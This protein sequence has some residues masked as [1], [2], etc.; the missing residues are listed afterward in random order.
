MSVGERLVATIDD[1]ASGEFGGEGAHGKAGFE[2]GIEGGAAA[3]HAP[4][5][6]DQGGIEAEVAREV[7]EGGGK[8]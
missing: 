2:D 3:P 6:G 1:A 8:V 7:V 5:Q 4:L